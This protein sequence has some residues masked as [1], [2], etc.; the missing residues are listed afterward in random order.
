MAS[1]RKDNDGEALQCLDSAFPFDD[2][3]WATM[4]LGVTLDEV[5]DN[6]YHE[7]ADRDQSHD[8]RV[9]QGIQAS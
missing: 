1:I 7:V 2:S 9:L 5:I 4:V 6:Q 3:N 8:T